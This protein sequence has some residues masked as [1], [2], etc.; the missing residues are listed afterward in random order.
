M[1]GQFNTSP[2]P[3][4]CVRSFGE[5]REEMLLSLLLL[6]P[7]MKSAIESLL[8]EQRSELSKPQLDWL[9]AEFSL[10]FTAVIQDSNDMVAYNRTVPSVAHTGSVYHT[11]SY[12]EGK[13]ITKAD[14]ECAVRYRR[15]LGHKGTV[16]QIW[17]FESTMGRLDIR[18]TTTSSDLIIGRYEDLG[19]NFIP[20]LDMPAT[21]INTNFRKHIFQ[22]RP[23][24]I[25]RQP[26][27]YT[28]LLYRECWELYKLLETGTLR[29]IDDAFRH[30]RTSPYV[31]DFVGRSV[32][33]VRCV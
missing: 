9:N 15:L 22:S 30:G 28:V 24:Q 12:Y 8:A 3:V 18:R 6:R 29:E 10:P 19:F 5:D 23:P 7:Q 13:M 1:L 20:F 26:Y 4:S 32:H 17:R 2:N 16:I 31:L 14:P 27:T 21:A 25:Q 11:S 33:Y